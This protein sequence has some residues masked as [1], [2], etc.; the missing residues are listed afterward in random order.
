MQERRILYSNIAIFIFY[1]Q[2]SEI[3]HR[4]ITQCEILLEFN[5]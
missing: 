3:E 2:T 5:K 1:T 4:T